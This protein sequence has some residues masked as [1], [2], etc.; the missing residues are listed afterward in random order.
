MLLFFVGLALLICVPFLIWGDH[1]EQLFTGD[2]LRGWMEDQGRGLVWASGVLLLVLDLLLPVPGTAVM[3]GLGYFYGPLLGGVLSAVG[4][5]LS[6]MLA[7]G[8]CRKYGGRAVARL[9]GPAEME[10]GERL[11][12]GQ[13]GGW[14]VVLSRWIPL[15]PEVV[16]CMAGL[17]R[18]PWGRFCLS[19]ACGSVPVGFV[20]AWIGAAGVDR[21]Q[22]ALGLSIGVPVVLY[23]V[24]LVFLKRRG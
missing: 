12:S 18:M 17:S 7:Y 6:G 14:L 15:L 24:A 8:L 10:R 11:F 9:L 4:S 3:S 16:A 22:L 21:P 2:A 19:L 20:F 23:G 13:G 5:F 1:F